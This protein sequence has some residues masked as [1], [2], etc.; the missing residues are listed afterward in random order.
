MKILKLPAFGMSA[1]KGNIVAWMAKEGDAL[2]KG[3]PLYEMESEKTTTT[4]EA[5]FDCI[6][7][8]I[9]VSSGEV[10]VNHPVA[11][12]SLPEEPF[13]QE[14]LSK[15]L[16]EA[17]EEESSQQEREEA[18]PEA[19]KADSGEGKSVRAT[20][21]A[22]KLAADL[23]V[24]LGEVEGTG[25]K[26]LVT[27]KDVKKHH[28]K[29]SAELDKKKEEPLE[30]SIKVENTYEKLKFTSIE[31]ASAAHL[32]KSWQTVPHIVQHLSVDAT[33]LIKAKSMIQEAMPISYNDL[34]AK[35]LAKALKDHPRINATMENDE[36]KLW[37]QVNI[38][39]AVETEKGLTV[40][41]IKHVGDKSLAE[42]HEE[43]A[44]KAEKAREGKLT[45]EDLQGGTITLSNLGMYGAETGLPIIN[46]PQVALVY[47]GSIR[48]EPWVKEN[49][50]TIVPIL[51][52]SIAFDHRVVDGAVGA[53]FAQQFK[54]VLENAIK[55]LMM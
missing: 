12:V 27:D 35:L 24:A 26:G 51:K 15:A 18:K 55:H 48:Q 20:P 29:Q 9:I 32:T 30:E 47:V 19:K 37:K 43:I 41:V 53:R 2:K 50:I 52:L 39:V 28:E 22:R 5:T 14:E 7:R 34:L 10:K 36:V 16:K 4:I 25:P 23:N 42:I 11:I 45:M 21:V 6:L 46:I 40:P 54:K 8:K 49:A 33:E 1:K 44:A 13:S 31:Q 38:S 17:G 3:D